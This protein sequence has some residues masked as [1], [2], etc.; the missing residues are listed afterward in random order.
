MK[1]ILVE[2]SHF[3]FFEQ[4]EKYN[5]D[6][7]TLLKD[8][9]LELKELSQ[10]LI[11]IF[12]SVKAL[13]N[14]HIKPYADSILDILDV[15]TITIFDNFFS[16]YTIDRDPKLE[17][18][19]KRIVKFQRSLRLVID[20]LS[21]TDSLVDP[22]IENKIQ[23]ISEKNDFILSKLNKL[24]GDGQ[25]SISML[26]F[27]NNVNQRDG[28][29][30]EIAEDLHRRGYIILENRYGTSDKVK[31]SIKGASYIERKVKQKSNKNSPNQLDKKIDNIIEHLTKL[32]Y[33]QE[34][35]FNE[36][37][38]LRELQHKLSRK[39]WTQLLKGKLIDLALDKLISIETVTSVYE[40]LTNNNFKLLK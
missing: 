38:E 16:S 36:L 39:S 8:E 33:G 9:R 18:E 6:L 34:I 13:I 1:Y 24:F 37:E 2:I 19:I 15:S 22:N 14:K 23:T 25:Y 35:I 29:G 3:D 5:A 21:I 7:E 30:R 20:Y 10:Q 27:L 31:I 26:L 17:K 12:E 40:Y 4:L 11:D 32:G 28:E